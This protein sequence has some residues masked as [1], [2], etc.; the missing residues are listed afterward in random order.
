LIKRRS[1]IAGKTVGSDT[2]KVMRKKT[3]LGIRERFL[4]VIMEFM[5]V[6]ELLQMPR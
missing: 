3:Q 5:K 2:M 1:I 4:R 6:V